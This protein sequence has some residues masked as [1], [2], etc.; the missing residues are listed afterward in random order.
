MSEELFEML[1][2]FDFFLRVS[3]P[4]WRIHIHPPECLKSPDLLVMEEKADPLL[5]IRDSEKIQYTIANGRIFNSATMSELGNNEAAPKFFWGN[6]SLG[7]IFSAPGIPGSG[8][9]RPGC[10]DFRERVNNN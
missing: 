5:N 1:T 10:E 6:G 2:G 4:P 8:C 3:V 7:T 9:L